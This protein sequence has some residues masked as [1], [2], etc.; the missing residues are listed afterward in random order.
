MV[1]DPDGQTWRRAGR[2]GEA[3]YRS[4]AM[5]SGYYRDEPATRE[6]FRYGW[7]HSG[8]SCAYDADGLR[9]MLDRYKDIIKTGGENVSSLRVEAV[10]AQHPD[11]AKS[12][13]I[14]LPH[15]R[16]GE[17]VTAVVIRRAGRRRREAELIRF[18]RQRLAGY[19]APKDV[20]FIDALPETVGGKVLKYKLRAT[21]SD[22]YG[23]IGA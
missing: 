15:D 12:A 11:V 20:M 22:H 2:A 16:W 3:V 14:G 17:A 10:L 7:F 1:M 8:D 21:F 19:E 23:R 6:A 9:I 13:V 4:P 18:C 5:M